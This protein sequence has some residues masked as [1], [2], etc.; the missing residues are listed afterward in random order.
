MPGACLT[1]AKLSLDLTI[2]TFSKKR[3]HP[4]M[5]KILLLLIGGFGND[6]Y[7]SSSSSDYVYSLAWVVY[8]GNCSTFPDYKYDTY[9]V[10]V[11]RAF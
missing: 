6:W 11:I 9:R 5:K 4:Q 1:T 10:R 7:W 8:F 2:R 3:K